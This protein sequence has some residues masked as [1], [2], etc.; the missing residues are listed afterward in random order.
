[1]CHRFIMFFFLPFFWFYFTTILKLVLIFDK[2][3]SLSQRASALGTPAGSAVTSSSIE[4]SNNAPIVQ[5]DA[6]GSMVL[7]PPSSGLDPESISLRRLSQMDV[8]ESDCSPE[9]GCWPK[10]NRL[11]SL[12]G[13]LL[14]RG[15]YVL[16]NVSMLAWSITFHSWLGF[17]LL[18]W[19]S[20]LWLLPNQRRAMLRTSP[21]LGLYTTALLLS[22]VKRNH[23]RI[24]Y[25]SKTV[26]KRNP[27]IDRILLFILYIEIKETFEKL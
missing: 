27:K 9:G 17:V 26:L 13:N 15:S 20:V 25:L 19:S 8:A 14:A 6:H 5:Q 11:A 22:Q 23:L 3:A 12:I 1:M 18:L 10:F 24:K 7:A 21:L 2:F 4:T 16:G